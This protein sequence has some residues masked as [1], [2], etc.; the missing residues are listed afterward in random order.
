MRLWGVTRT[1]VSSA[2]ARAAQD[3]GSPQLG[4]LREHRFRALLDRWLRR[5]LWHGQPVRSALLLQGTNL[6]RRLL[7]E[8]RTTERGPGQRPCTAEPDL[9]PLLLP[10]PEH[11]A[12][13]TVRR[14]LPAPHGQTKAIR[15]LIF[16][17]RLFLVNFSLPWLLCN[18]AEVEGWC[19]TQEQALAGATS[20]AGEGAAEGAQGRLG[21]CTRQ[22]VP[23]C[24]ARPRARV[25]AQGCS[26]PAKTA[27]LGEWQMHI[28]SSKAGTPGNG[29]M[30]QVSSGGGSGCP[31]LNVCPGEG[32]I[33]LPFVWGSR[34]G[35]PGLAKAGSCTALGRGARWG[36]GTGRGPSRTGGLPEPEWSWWHSG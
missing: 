21:G 1:P 32:R 9:A 8:L 20:S 31:V 26:D 29:R 17:K 25:C 15:T 18:K 6:P 34:E 19:K 10:C 28:N 24:N 4:L 2:P 36:S 3:T 30:R 33:L 5:L 13:P 14:V 27:G 16:R 23:L 22:R 35:W 12:R 11:T 7:A